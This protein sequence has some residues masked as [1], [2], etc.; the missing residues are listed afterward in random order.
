MCD[1][2]DQLI[3][4]DAIL[5]RPAQMEWKLVG[6]VACDE[7]RHGNEAPVTFGEARPF[8]D[9]PEEYL[10][11]QFIRVRGQCRRMLCVRLSVHLP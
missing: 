10:V 8:P 2:F 3:L 4:S 11:R 6:A 7:C 1:E 5:N 9:F